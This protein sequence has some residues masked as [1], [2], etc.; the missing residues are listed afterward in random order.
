MNAASNKLTPYLF[1]APALV[2]FL[3]FL[4]YPM[5]HSL[6]VSLTDWDGLSATWHFVGLSNYVTIFTDPASRAALS[7]T[8]IWSAVMVT[9]PTI[10]GLGM[11]VTLNQKLR[12]RTFF[13][14]VFYGPTILPLSAVALIWVWL[15][16]PHF[17]L[18][19][20]VLR[21]IGL[22]SWAKGWLSNFDTA[23]PAVL[24][25]AIWHG[26]GFP[27]LLYLAGLQGVSP[28][29]YEAAALDGAGPW[30][31]F[32]HVTLPGLKETHIVVFTLAIIGSVRSFELIYAMTY[33]GPGRSTQVLATWMYFNIFQYNQAGA[34]SAIAWLIAAISLAVTIPYIRLMS[35]R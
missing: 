13:R 12:G 35:R 31:R 22:K 27:M 1:M 5:M 26:A 11:A 21:G 23:L 14:S 30:R 2:L 17:G 3:G 24:V 9:V 8:L 16:N 15:Y 32:I 20:E 25:T 29:Q 18:I 10:L 33:G 7:N 34:G 19:N 4:V 28:S 6:V